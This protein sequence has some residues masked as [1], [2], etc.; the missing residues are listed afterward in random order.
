MKNEAVLKYG[1]S[2]LLCSTPL[3][4]L[5]CRKWSFTCAGKNIELVK[6][7]LPEKFQINEKSVDSLIEIVRQIRYCKGVEH[8]NADLPYFNTASFFI[9]PIFTNS[10]FF[11]AQVKLH[12][13]HNLKLALSSPYC[14]LQ[15]CL[16]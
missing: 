6:I 4:Y 5:I 14:H 10:I 15:H 11:P 13:H 3:Q 7:G 2:A 9:R 16:W 8:N 12:F 1:K